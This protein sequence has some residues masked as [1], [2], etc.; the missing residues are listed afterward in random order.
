MQQQRVRVKICGLTREDDVHQAVQAGADAIGMVFYPG[1]KRAVD[2]T[3][4]ARLRR[5]VPGFVSTVALFVNPT[6]DAV[7]QV[8][9]QVDPDLLQFHGDETPD[10]C[11]RF[12]RR[13]LK[14][15]RVGAPGLQSPDEIAAAC[16][17]YGNAAGW[18]FDSHSAGYGGSG[19]R[20][21]TGLLSRVME[22]PDAR[23]I[24]LAG[25]L[26]PDNVADGI[27]AL[28]PYAVDVSSGVEVAPGLKSADRILQF[29]QAVAATAASSAF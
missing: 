1:S 5:L 4:A 29:M 16:A 6:P 19:V 11:A 10:D 21:D 26:T 17:A 13:Y 18:L 22:L 3:Q 7:A 12:G 28:R 9:A 24:M 27:A 8:I 20:F 2:L 14:A 23:P 15:F 25:G